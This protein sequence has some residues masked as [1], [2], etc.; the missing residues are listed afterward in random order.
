M[1]K[2]KIYRNIIMP[3]VLYGCE[4]WSLTLREERRLRVFQNRVLRRVFG[5]KRDVVTGGWRNLYNKEISDV[6]S[7]PKIVRVVKS[8][9]M[10]WAGHVALMGEGCTGFWWGNLRER[11]H[12]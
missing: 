12:C 5:P 7:L 11:E 4:T 10:R 1:L 9:G 2:I 3:V 8:R 6:Y